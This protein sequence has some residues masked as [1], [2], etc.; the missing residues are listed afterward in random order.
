MNFDVTA[1]AEPI[2]QT[3]KGVITYIKAHAPEGAIIAGVTG[4]FASLYLMYKKSPDMHKDI[5]KQD[6]KQLAKDAAPVAIS[7]TAST[8]AVFAGMKENSTRL[9]AVT[10]LAESTSE[11]LTDRKNAE[12]IGLSEK[13]VKDIDTAQAEN[14]V[15]NNP[16]KLECVT[17]IGNGTCLHYDMRFKKWFRAEVD[18]VNR[19]L[20]DFINSFDSL[21]EG[22]LMPISDYYN[23]LGYFEAVD[24][25]N[26][27]SIYGHIGWA[28]PI[29]RRCTEDDKPDMAT[30]TIAIPTLEPVRVIKWRNLVFNDGYGNSIE[31]PD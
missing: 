14:S 12:L 6:W 13:K 9:A 22:E 25:L 17:Q 24:E 21:D 23:D 5:E 27:N 16:P 29:D 7:T 1:F 30:Y 18:A 4:Y 28:K 15:A 19:T 11:A 2:R 8:I 20:I 26:D 3:T 10:A 31:I